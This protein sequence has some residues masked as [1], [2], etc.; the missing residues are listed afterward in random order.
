[1]GTGIALAVDAP[2]ALI[3]GNKMN[4]LRK[5]IGSVLVLVVGMLACGVASA[6]PITMDFDG[7]TLGASVH[8][9]Y[10]G[11]CTRLLVP[12]DCG[13]PDYGVRWDGA[14][15]GD[16]SDAPSPSGFAGLVFDDSATM[17]VAA[18]FDGGLSFYFY[19]LKF[20]FPGSVSVY[21]GENGHGT[22]LTHADLGLTFDWDFFDLSFSGTAKSV[23]F[24]G[25]GFYLTGFDN[26]T[27][28][29]SAT[30]VPEPAALGVFGLGL[31]LMG[32]FA[33]LRRR[34]H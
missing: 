6:A 26:V 21:S 13:G 31:L 30:S 32:L 24:S 8:N 25:A 15:I 1:M 5:Q 16:S 3:Q 22:Q 10:D 7:L 23:I 14:R 28:G 33:G 11:G 18:G 9:Y 20:P 27:L 29:T 17:N 4:L 12:R 19:N 2:M 34:S